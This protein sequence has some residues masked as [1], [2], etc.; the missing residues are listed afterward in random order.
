MTTTRR[1]RRSVAHLTSADRIIAERL[2]LDLFYADDP[3]AWAA[4]DVALCQHQEWLVIAG[5]GFG[6]EFM[7]NHVREFWTSRHDPWNTDDVIQARRAAEN[8]AFGLSA[9]AVIYFGH[10]DVTIDVDGCSEQLRY[11][12]AFPEPVPE[13]AVADLVLMWNHW[14][15]QMT[16]TGT[17]PSRDEFA[18]VTAR[19]RTLHPS[20]RDHSF[21]WFSYVTDQFAGEQIW[22]SRDSLI[23]MTV[24]PDE[25][26]ENS[27]MLRFAALAC[28]AWPTVTA[29]DDPLQRIVVVP[30]LVADALHRSTHMFT[31]EAAVPPGVDVDELIAVAMQMRQNQNDGRDFA[32]VVFDAAEVL[33]C[34][35]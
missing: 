21:T 8:M 22:D 12:V 3:F 9:P 10:D 2:G 15:S 13:G 6:V 17:E 35:N 24:P 1:R 25:S 5:Q 27:L 34:P 23:E 31:E 26:F 29:H 33:T 20:V 32:D 19:S 28:A 4:R 30:G 11:D 14:L 7:E 16:L 18:A